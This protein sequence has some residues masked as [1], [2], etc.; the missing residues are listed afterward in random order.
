MKRILVQLGLALALTTH[1]KP[2][3]FVELSHDTVNVWDTAFEWY[4]SGRF[5]SITRTSQDTIYVTE[6]DT[7]PGAFCYC[8]FDVCTRLTGLPPGDY[9]AVVTRRYDW[10]DILYTEPAGSVQFTILTPS[11]LANSLSVLQSPCYHLPQA[12]PVSPGVPTEM[13]LLST[14]PNP[15]NSTATIQYEI[16]RN[17]HVSLAIYSMAG[18]LV[19]SLVQDVK[20]GGTYKLQFDFHD[21]A[22]GLYLCRLVYNLQ[23]MTR[24]MV[25]Q[26]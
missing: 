4:C 26:K 17:G 2:G 6:C 5:F 24:K 14:Y 23:T 16:P 25:L 1:A 22:S 15:F 18:Q 10:L 20:S 8:H 3:V 7:V 19:A 12:V 9:V 11:P 13:A 21:L